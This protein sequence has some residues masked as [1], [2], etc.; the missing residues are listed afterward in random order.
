MYRPI[1]EMRWQPYMEGRWNPFRQPT[2]AYRQVPLTRWEARKEVVNRTTMKTR[3]IAEKRTVETPTQIVRFED[4][5]RVEYEPIARVAPQSTTNGA[6]TA[7]ASRLRP[8]PQ[9][10]PVESLHRSAPAPVTVASNTV[11]LATSD[12]PRRNANQSGMRT[13]HLIPNR[14]PGAALIPGAAGTSIATQPAFSI[15]R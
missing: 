5:Q 2:V 15:R 1:T 8:L 9:G 7:I 3:W 4:E 12:P 14:S 11:G 13:N 10:T 6:N